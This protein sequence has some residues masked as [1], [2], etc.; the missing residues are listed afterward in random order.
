M[1]FKCYTFHTK[2]GMQ[3]I[4][5]L[6]H[7]EISPYFGWQISAGSCHFW[8]FHGPKFALS[9]S[10]SMSWLCFQSKNSLSMWRTLALSI[11][12]PL[13]LNICITFSPISFTFQDLQLWSDEIFVPKLFPIPSMY[14]IFTYIHL[15]DFCGKCREIYQSHGSYGF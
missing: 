9:G 10:C 13:G 5:A 6:T 14:G 3:D 4:M 1:W 11:I 7:L 12:G 8:N 15:V 2:W